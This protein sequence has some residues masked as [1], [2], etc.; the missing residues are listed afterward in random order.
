MHTMRNES[1]QAPPNLRGKHTAGTC[2]A[3]PSPHATYTRHPPTQAS[4]WAVC[5]SSRSKEITQL[6]CFVAIHRHAS[7]VNHPRP[8]AATPHT[9]CC[10]RRCSCCWWA[11]AARPLPPA[12][13][14]R[15]AA[16]P[17]W[18]PCC[19]STNLRP[20]CDAVCVGGCACG[21]AS[22]CWPQPQRLPAAHTM[23]TNWRTSRVILRTSPSFA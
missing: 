7:M 14:A 21:C 3:L 2:C 1:N 18:R 4:P 11:A 17:C 15:P 8:P 6:S 13:A 9:S 10:M 20:R 22:A 16:T 5:R 12:S 19:N 23:S